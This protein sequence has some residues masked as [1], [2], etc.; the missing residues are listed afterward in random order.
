MVIYNKKSLQ[1]ITITDCIVEIV[2]RNSHHN[3]NLINKYDPMV[4]LF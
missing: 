4:H 2:E 3:L 1:N